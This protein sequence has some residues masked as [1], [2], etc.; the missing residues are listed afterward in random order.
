MQ[1]SMRTSDREQS[2]IE[3]EVTHTFHLWSSKRDREWRRTL[4]VSSLSQKRSTRVPFYQLYRYKH[5]ET[6]NEIKIEFVP[7]SRWRYTMRKMISE[8]CNLY[9]RMIPNLRHEDLDDILSYL[10]RYPIHVV[11][12]IQIIGVLQTCLSTLAFK[13]DVAFFK[14]KNSYEGISYATISTSCIQSWIILLYVRRRRVLDIIIIDDNPTGT[15]TKTQAWRQVGSYCSNSQYTHVSVLGKQFEFE[16]QFSVLHSYAC[17]GSAKNKTTQ[18]QQHRDRSIE[19]AC[20]PCSTTSL[21]LS[22]FRG[23]LIVSTHTTL[24]ADDT[25]FGISCSRVQPIFHIFS[26]F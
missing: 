11:L 19:R 21:H 20:N 15:Y 13:N 23:R 14:G 4:C 18:R 8:S 5:K 16:N 26:D 25:P 9:V 12:F 3:A 24:I 1:E 10:F 7:I 22:W 17:H 2:N 6:G